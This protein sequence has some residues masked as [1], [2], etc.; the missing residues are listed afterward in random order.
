MSSRRN[1]LRSALPVLS[2]YVVALSAQAQQGTPSPDDYRKFD[3]VRAFVQ[4]RNA[5]DYANSGDNAI[6]EGKYVELGGIGLDTI[7]E[8][9]AGR[10]I[11]VHFGPRRPGDPPELVADPSRAR[12]V[13]GWEA[14]YPDARDAVLSAWRWMTGPRQGRYAPNTPGRPRASG[15]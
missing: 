9:V 13:L 7:A 12:D 11:P 1:L 10:P 2:C 4:A 15:V 14:E 5:G 6:D 8:E 3:A